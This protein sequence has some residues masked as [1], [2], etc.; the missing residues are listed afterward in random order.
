M[1]GRI[2]RLQNLGFEPVEF[3]LNGPHL[4]AAIGH[5]RSSS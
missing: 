1:T 4:R 2:P 5:V 3:L